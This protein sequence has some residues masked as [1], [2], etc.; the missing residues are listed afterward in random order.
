MV[1]GHLNTGQTIVQYVNYHWQ[2]PRKIVLEEHSTITEE[3][4][5]ELMESLKMATVSLLVVFK[6]SPPLNWTFKHYFGV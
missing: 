6:K 2:N 3:W 4:Q 1:Q 5:P